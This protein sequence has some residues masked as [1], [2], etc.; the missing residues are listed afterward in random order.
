MPANTIR[1]FGDVNVK[2][3]AAIFRDYGWA[4]FV[5][6]SSDTS[7]AIDLGP[8]A[9]IA[10]NCPLSENGKSCAIQTTSDG[11]NWVTL[12]SVTLATGMNFL[13]GDNAIK[14]MHCQMTRLVLGSATSG[15]V[16]IPVSVKG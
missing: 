4:D 8:A 11:S 6:A 16:T 15:T 14:V 2:T 7:N 12:V 1:K 10:I 9:T 3:K 13:T 5:F